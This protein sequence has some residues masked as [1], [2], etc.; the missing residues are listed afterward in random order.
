M[1]RVKFG[2]WLA[3]AAFMSGLIGGSVVRG[4]SIQVE[5]AYTLA[6]PFLAA[7]VLYVVFSRNEERIEGS[8]W[9]RM[10]VFI[11]VLFTA[12]SALSL[13]AVT[14]GLGVGGL[15]GMGTQVLAFLAGLGA[16]VW[17]AYGGLGDHLWN[18]YALDDLK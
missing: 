16:A 2:W 1:D 7:P 15:V 5:F 17:V 13:I 10:G 4:P 3:F 9:R 18:E 14:L 8:L 11:V 12:G 6:F